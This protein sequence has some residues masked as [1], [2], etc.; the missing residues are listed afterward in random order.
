MK[1]VEKTGL[2]VSQNRK[3]F[4]I[5]FWREDIESPWRVT[6]QAADSTQ[7]HH[8]QTIESFVTQ[9]DKFIKDL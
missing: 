3:A 2:N 5:R 4:L 1:E 9:I 8:F 6:L 7:K